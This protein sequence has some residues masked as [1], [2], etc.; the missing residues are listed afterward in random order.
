MLAKK[1]IFGNFGK[2]KHLK[3]L[4][5]KAFDGLKKQLNEHNLLMK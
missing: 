4:V 5:K 2:K 1:K 3:I